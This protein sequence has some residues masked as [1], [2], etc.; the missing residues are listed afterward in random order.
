LHGAS[1]QRPA[2]HPK[3]FAIQP[4]TIAQ[5]QFSAG[6]GVRRSAAL[7]L[8]LTACTPARAQLDLMKA[9]SEFRARNSH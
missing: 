8:G 5:R 7:F 3:S 4:V 9:E 6:F 1:K 2:P